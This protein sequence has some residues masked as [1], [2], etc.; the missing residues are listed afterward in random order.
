MTIMLQKEVSKDPGMLPYSLFWPIYH[1]LY[2][3][4]IALKLGFLGQWDM[5]KRIVASIR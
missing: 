5:G 2:P 3:L 1:A 4:Y